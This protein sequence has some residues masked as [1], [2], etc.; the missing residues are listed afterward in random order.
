MS[1]TL[2]DQLI[3]EGKTEGEAKGEIKGEAKGKADG[4]IRTLTKRIAQPSEELEKNLRAVTDL[5]QLD[6]L[7]DVAFDCQSLDE[8]SE[9][10]K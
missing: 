10:L 5:E 4:I 8:F 3:E 1:A 2:W 7:F 6:Q 9:E